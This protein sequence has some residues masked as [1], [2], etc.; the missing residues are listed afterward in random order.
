MK[1][2]AQITASAC[3]SSKWYIVPDY[4]V[5]LVRDNSRSV[6]ATGS[7]KQGIASPDDAV[8]IFRAYLDGLDRE[9]FCVTLLDTKTVL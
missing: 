5:M 8:G 1:T 3:E 2:P 7:K 9:V 6:K 4:K